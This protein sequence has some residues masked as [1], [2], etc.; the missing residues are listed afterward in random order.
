M[1]VSFVV[2]EPNTFWLVVTNIALGAI[3]LVL[4]LGVA[5]GV[6]CEF[7]QRFRNRRSA[8]RELDRDIQQMFHPGAPK[9]HTP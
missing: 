3:V 4:V 9:G 1:L 5:T 7:V 8:L 6:I 2:S